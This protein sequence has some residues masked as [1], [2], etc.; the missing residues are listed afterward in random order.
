MILW[1]IVCISCDPLSLSN[2][3]KHKTAGTQ[4][5]S[6]VPPGQAAGDRQPNT[7]TWGM[8]K[9]FALR[10]FISYAVF[11]FFRRGPS[12]PGPISSES[13]VPGH[14]TH[15]SLGAASNLFA[16]GALMDL[17]AYV[18]EAPTFDAFDKASSTLQP[19]GAK[20]PLFWHLTD[21]RYGDW[22][23]GEYKDG[24]YIHEATIEASEVCF[25]YMIS[26]FTNRN[27]FMQMREVA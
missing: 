4:A 15:P 27:W 10:L 5:I 8:L 24:S 2:W 16:A 11:S 3:L 1:L 17:Y 18:N 20:G 13:G 7:N 26:L 22:E 9:A 25:T 21:L 19:H 23:A 14:P 12:T 6:E